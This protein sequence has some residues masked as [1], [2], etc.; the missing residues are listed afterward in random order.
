MKKLIMSVFVITLFLVSLYAVNATY[1][2]DCNLCPNRPIKSST[3]IPCL[4]W[5]SFKF[6]YNYILAIKNRITV[7][8]NWKSK[9]QYS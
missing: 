8:E 5:K 7:L 2:N 3:R 1:V 6:G 4:D 9:I